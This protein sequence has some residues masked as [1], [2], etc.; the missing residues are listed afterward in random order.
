MSSSGAVQS[1]DQSYWAN[2][3]LTVG[4]ASLPRVLAQN[5]AVALASGTMRLSYF[6]ALKTEVINNVKSDSRGTASA[7]P[8]L[9]RMGFYSVAANG[10]IALLAACAS[11]TAIWSVTNTQYVAALTGP[12]NKVAGTWYAAAALYTGT[13]GPT[14]DGQN[15]V[16]GAESALANR[17]CGI[18]TGQVDLPATVVNALITAQAS[19]P[20]IVALP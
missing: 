4:E 18:V 9:C 10:D 3:L 11:D 2:T 20:Y 13:T 7:V 8:T 17:I 15:L 6:R 14:I 16:L 5:G 19:N 12:F 1:Y